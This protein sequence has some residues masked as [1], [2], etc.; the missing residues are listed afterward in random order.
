MTYFHFV[1][2][3]TFRYFNLIAFCARNLYSSTTPFSLSNLFE[4]VIVLLN[5]LFLYTS[6]FFS[7]IV[8][9]NKSYQQLEFLKIPIRS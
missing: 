5:S 6:L 9:E 3:W 2:L 1:R 7:T 4:Q 8:T